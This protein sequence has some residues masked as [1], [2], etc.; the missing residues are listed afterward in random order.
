MSIAR[1]EASI[2]NWLL[3]STTP[4]GAEK[5]FDSRIALGTDIGTTR[6]ENQDRVAALSFKFSGRST[7]LIA[8]A[9]GMGGLKDG[10]VC[11]AIA[12]ASF[13]HF[14]SNS[15]QES[16]EEMLLQAAHAANRSVFDR[17][18]GEGGATISAVMLAE[19]VVLGLNVGDS[20]IY[21]LSEGQLKQQTI[22][23]TLAGHLNRM[24]DSDLAESGLLQ[25][26]GCGAD[27]APHLIE[28]HDVD[29]GLLLTSDGVHFLP[30]AV[31]SSIVKLAPNAL[32]TIRRLL[33]VSKWCGG[34]DNGTAA[35][36]PHHFDLPAAP[37]PGSAT[38]RDSFGE[39]AFLLDPSQL[40]AS[41]P[42]VQGPD[43]GR[44]EQSPLP[45]KARARKK[46]TK[47]RKNKERKK[48]ENALELRVDLF[49]D[50]EK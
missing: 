7:L 40:R 36:I 42:K 28:I 47:E 43:L 8:L 34:H 25:F 4:S 37:S 49:G 27:L 10:D 46:S 18:K 23:D 15:M 29:G 30:N 3:R 17:Y 44:Y 2:T 6:G 5:L 20:R 11:A 50:D 21:K 24:S 35:F 14:A 32:T 38:V 1:I 19:G 33:A 26:L 16:A 9:D 31:M 12:L 22:D 41:E 45:S 39:L 13:F 48:P